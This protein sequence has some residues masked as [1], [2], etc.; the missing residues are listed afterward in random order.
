MATIS[1]KRWKRIISIM[2][3]L[4]AIFLIIGFFYSMWSSIYYKRSIKSNMRIVQ[5]GEIIKIERLPKSSNLYAVS[6]KFS[7]NGDIYEGKIK[8]G[9]FISEV[10]NVKNNSFPVAY[11]KDDITNAFILIKPEDFEYFDIAYP[12]SLNRN[13][14]YFNATQS[15]RTL[16]NK[17]FGYPC[18][19]RT[20][21]LIKQISLMLSVR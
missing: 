14:K 12:D 2:V 13:R 18:A 10:S 7:V 6:F 8:N 3:M 1:K 4:L 5:G 15:Q 19:T 21:I 16:H 17:S 20:M 11:Q 9:Y